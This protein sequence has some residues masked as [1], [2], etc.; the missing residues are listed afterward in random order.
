[1]PQSRLWGLG[2]G[3]GVKL[4]LGQLAVWKLLGSCLLLAGKLLGSC[5]QVVRTRAVPA[6]VRAWALVAAAAVVVVA[7]SA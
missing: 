7:D 3:L 5:W 4:L 6:A 2:A 1:M